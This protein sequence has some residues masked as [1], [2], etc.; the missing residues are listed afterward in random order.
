[1]ALS[2]Y[3]GMWADMVIASRTSDYQS[4]LLPQHASGE[5]L[6]VLVQGLAKNRLIGV[7]TKGTPSIHPQVTSLS[8]IGTPTQVTITD[9]VNDAHWLEYKVA[10]GLL[11]KIPGGGHAS[12][13]IVVDSGSDWKVT[14]LAV[15]MV[16][17]C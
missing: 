7:I 6:S 11:N 2:A 12:T 8:P 17:T 9:C 1:M 3:R 13:A 16:G 14:Q 4:P 10:G 15:Q 5:A